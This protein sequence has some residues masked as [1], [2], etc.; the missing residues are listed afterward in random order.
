MSSLGFSCGVCVVWWE[1]AACVPVAVAVHCVSAASATLAVFWV[2][3]SC[4]GGQRVVC[5][6]VLVQWGEIE[7]AYT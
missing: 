5:W 3:V 6:R 7:A 2:C 4:G 1:T